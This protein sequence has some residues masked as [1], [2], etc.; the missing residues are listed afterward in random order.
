MLRCRGV[1]L[2]PILP[3]VAV[4]AACVAPLGQQEGDPGRPAERSQSTTRKRS[5]AVVERIVCPLVEQ[6]PVT[7]HRF[8]A[9]V[10]PGHDAEGD[11]API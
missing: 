6:L 1:L 10:N 8:S 3:D 4:D 7:G 5:K 11:L 9:L 2:S